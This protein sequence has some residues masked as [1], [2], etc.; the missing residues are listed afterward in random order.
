[1][2]VWGMWDDSLHG[3]IAATI[4]EQQRYRFRLFEYAALGK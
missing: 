1:M 4:R 2:P 3:R